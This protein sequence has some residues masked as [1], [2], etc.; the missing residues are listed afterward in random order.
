MTKFSQMKPLQYQNVSPAPCLCIDWWTMIKTPLKGLFR[1][2]ITESKDKQRSCL[3]CSRDIKPLHR[4][5]RE[6]GWSQMEKLT[7]KVQQLAYMVKDG[8]GFLSNF[9]L[10]H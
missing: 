6:A 3:T 4:H 10:K 9:A 1:P 7:C 2:G 5:W 8:E